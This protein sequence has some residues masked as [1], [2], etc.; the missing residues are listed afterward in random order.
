M[1]CKF[2]GSLR[3]SKQGRLGT[4]KA[5][6]RCKDCGKWGNFGEIHRHRSA[7][8]LLLDIETLPMEAY[9]WN[10]KQEYIQPDM[11]IKDWSISCWAAKWLFESEIM[12]EVVTPQEASDRTEQSI[13]SGIW[14]LM[15]EA[16]IIVTQNGIAFDIKRINT[17]FLQHGF[18]PPA[19]YLNVDTLRVAQGVFGFSYNRLNELGKK[20][21]IGQ[22]IE[23]DFQDWKDCL[24]NDKKADKA[25]KHKLE[26]CKNDVAP[27]LE[28]V[29]LAMLPWMQNH[30]NLSLYA[31]QGGD[32]CPR[33][34]SEKLEWGLQ[35]PTP[36][37]L[38]NGWRC[39]SCNSIGRGTLKEN[40]LTSATLR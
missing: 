2:C 6:Y 25:L 7:K 17:K 15:N 4:G 30:P 8:I 35:Y 31:I 10:P 9:I 24:T 20:L 29:Y 38:W 40:R 39:I 12:G 1:N 22:K 26:Y 18:V 5:R 28:D 27:L 21:G 34:E 33:C 16:D 19:K 23:M 11:V 37:G 3:L 32:T 13:L 36:S 14:K